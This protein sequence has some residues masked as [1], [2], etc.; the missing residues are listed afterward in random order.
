MRYN[1]SSTRATDNPHRMVTRHVA[2]ALVAGGLATVLGWIGFA[3]VAL[4]CI[5]KAPHP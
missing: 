2:N 5:L 4:Q 3:V 1:T